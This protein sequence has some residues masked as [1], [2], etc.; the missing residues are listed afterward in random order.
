MKSV[1]YVIILAACSLLAGGT[2]GFSGEISEHKAVLV[3]GTSSGN[4]LQ[5][6]ETLSENGFYVDTGGR[7]PAHV[8]R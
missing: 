4:G 6:N 2:A 1:S 3:T 8:R 5:I 7:L